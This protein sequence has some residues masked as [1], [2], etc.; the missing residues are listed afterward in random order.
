LKASL[1]LRLVRAFADAANSTTP[2]PRQRRPADRHT[3]AGSV[4]KCSVSIESARECFQ[5]AGGT[6]FTDKQGI[7]ADVTNESE[8]AFA[9][10]NFRQN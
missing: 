10:P 6:F 1:D 3:A 9:D 4:P 5:S 8:F 2:S 7:S